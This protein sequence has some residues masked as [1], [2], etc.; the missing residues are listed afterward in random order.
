VA[1]DWVWGNKPSGSCAT[2]LVTLKANKKPVPW[3]R[4]LKKLMIAQLVKN[5]PPFMKSEDLLS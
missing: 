4:V 1:G 3:N 2:K 5:T